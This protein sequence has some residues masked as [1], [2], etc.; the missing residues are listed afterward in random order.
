MKD[1]VIIIGAGQAGLCASYFLTQFGFQHAVLEAGQ[2]GESWRSQRWDSFCLVTPNWTVRLPGMTPSG[3]PDAFMPCSDLIE[4]IG[5]FANSFSAPIEQ[6]TRVTAIR[7]ATGGARFELE[8][9]RGTRG[10]DHPVVCCGMYQ[11]IRRPASAGSLPADIHQ[12]DVT[13]YRNPEVLEDGAVL[14]VGSG[15]SGAQIA[16][17][18]HGS[19]RDVFLCVG[20]AGRIPR[21]YR[22]RDL[23][24]WQ[25]DMGYLNRTV[26]QLDSPADRFRGDPHVSGTRGGHTLN[27]HQFARNGIRLL[28]S[29]E[30]VVGETIYLA[31][32]LVDNMRSADAFAEA[33]CRSVDDYVREN[34]IWAPAPDH[35][36]SDLGGGVGDYPVSPRQLDLRSAGIRTVIWATG[37]GFDFSWIDFPIFDEFGYPYTRRGVTEVDGLYFL[38][39]NWLHT[40]KSGIILGAADDARHVVEH[41]RQQAN[42]HAR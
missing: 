42:G 24:R 39:L 36:N 3:N 41:L 14:V 21:R 38:G 29:L 11:T 8:T 6:S 35:E 31:D 27:L 1:D 34:G 4:F 22:G 26:D 32:N 5:R 20:K 12:I 10:C 23:S 37:F 13:S 17:E 15:Q 9:T 25:V 2:I 18:I 19:G 33:F 28:G 7:R 16:E 40:R 30:G